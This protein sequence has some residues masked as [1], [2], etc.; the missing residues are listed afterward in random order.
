VKQ[1][2]ILPLLGPALVLYLL[3]EVASMGGELSRR[4]AL[5]AV[6]ALLSSFT[7]FWLR[8]RTDLRGTKRVSLLGVAAGVA[9]LTEGQA[10]LP[11]LTLQLMATVA[12]PLAA[13]LVADLA[14]AS[15]DRLRGLRNLRLALPV[16]AVVSIVA[17]VLALL[18]P[19][20]WLGREWIFP[21]RL[22]PL[23]HAF[24]LMALAFALLL[25]LLRS[26]LGSGP[27]ALASN[28]WAL[29]G[30]VPATSCTVVLAL[31]PSPLDLGPN[32]RAAL[33][34][35]VAFGLVYGH[36]SL[37]D[38][39]R[40]LRAGAAW[41][42]LGTFWLTLGVLALAV[43][44][45]PELPSSRV[46]LWLLVGVGLGT[47][48][49]LERLLAPLAERLL[50]PYAGRLLSAAATDP[51]ELGQ[52]RSLTELGQALLPGLRAAC[53][54]L[55][56]NPLLYTVDP[57]TEV[58]IDAAS[59]AHGAN[60]GMP[61][62]IEA[63]LQEKPGEMIVTSQLLGLVVRRPDLRP[64]VESLHAL[65][66]LAIVPLRNEDTLEGALVV[67]RG[68]RRS[69]LSLEE[70]LALTKLAAL[71]SGAASRIAALS[72]A[73]AR[74][75]TLAREHER[76]HEGMRALEE[77]MKSLRE[78]SRALLA[79]RGAGR[80]LAPAISYSPSMRALEEDIARV[81]ALPG[82][83]L[84]LAEGG[85]PVD[86]IAA[87]IHVGS[88]RAQGPLLV[89]DCAASRPEA[90]L[91]A[92]LGDADGGL[93]WLRLAR[94]G[95][96][97]LAD[98]PA[99]GLEA[100]HALSEALAKRK[101]RPRGGTGAYDVDVRVVATSRVALENIV[102]EGRF[103]PE[104]A[105]RLSA[106][107]LE[108][109]PLRARR[110][111]IPSLALLAIDRACRLLGKAP[112]GLDDEALELLLSHDWP[113]NLR[114]LSHVIDRAVA[115]A[116]GPK[117]LC[118]DLPPFAQARPVPTEDDPL[119]GSFAEVERRLLSAALARAAGNK[120]EAARSLGLKR[121]TF[122]DKLRRLGLEDRVPGAKA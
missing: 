112:V 118:A 20:S 83:V 49:L 22:A 39:Q 95:T 66:A 99:L 111:D 34:V 121:T 57:P 15:P 93:G 26:R 120:S 41:R 86:R 74:L 115:R 35:G 45:L 27:E 50:A 90:S 47:A 75:G 97:L 69:A 24:T 70:H 19:F 88:A 11:S 59:L 25:R 9:L 65:D 76:M 37:V 67:P 108:A 92:L 56:G 43:R 31:T 64:L 5:L 48:A 16:L 73:E 6:A 68:R 91:S 106:L 84:L 113:G 51:T 98:I 55:E 80:K 32:V 61:P 87:Q 29:M 10:M 89:V 8:R 3:A 117:I 52:A 110:D 2:R 12:S 21:A 109:P 18:P 94:G 42:R 36:L 116:R 23:P 72:R 60:R 96:L 1:N 33:L 7:P 38:P 58:H 114:E 119:D 14:L 102:R 81:S 103:D 101:A 100:E 105:T 122:L 28:A 40:R 44:F 79:G 30:L 53:G 17:G 13:A 78:E 82:S 85:V 4:G 77:D 63:R 71:T 104:L 62:A 54:S 46:G 107:R